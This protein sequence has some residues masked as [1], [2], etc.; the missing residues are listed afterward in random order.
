MGSA[1]SRAPRVLCLHSFRTSGA[2]FREQCF[3]FSSFGAKLEAAGFELDFPDAPYRC[4]PEDEEKVYPVVKEAFPACTTYHEWYNASDD[5][6]EY[7]RLGE[8]IAFLER[9]MAENGPYAGVVG[10]SQG[11]TL[12]H[13]VAYLQASGA[14]FTRHPPL[15][16]LVVLCARRSRAAAHARFWESAPLQAL[17]RALVIAGGRDDAVAPAEVQKIAETLPGAKVW[18]VPDCAHAVPNLRPEQVRELWDFLRDAST[19]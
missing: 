1:E 11:G 4:T 5:H 16:F 7:R 19:S 13:L 2:I 9:Y 3:N 10:F 8:T 15:R 18:T 17:P 12:A 14:A 6:S